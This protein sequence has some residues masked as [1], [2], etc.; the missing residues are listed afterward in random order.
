[1]CIRD[2]TY[3][4][5]HKDRIHPWLGSTER[6]GVQL[7]NDGPNIPKYGVA[8]ELEAE[9]VERGAHLEM[10]VSWEKPGFSENKFGRFVPL[11]QGIT[12]MPNIHHT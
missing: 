4:D 12:A 1:M 10:L 6:R 11:I 3:T 5:T 7:S 2:R 8:D 9:A